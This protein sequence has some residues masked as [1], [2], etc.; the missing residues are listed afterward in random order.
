MRFPTEQKKVGFV[1]CGTQ[2]GGT[3]ALYAYLKKHPEI[4]VSD[5]K[6][7][8]FFDDDEKFSKGEP[9]YS[10]Y[11]ARFSP[12]KS[13]KLV[14]ESTPQYMYWESAP[15]RM[16][17]YN[18]DMKLIVLLRNPIDRAYSHWN[19]GRT[20]NHHDLSFWDA[21]T[22]EKE[23]ARE[24]LPLQHKEHSYI[25]RG[26][27]LEQLK[28]LWAYFP[29]EHVLV[30]KS[31]DLKEKPEKTLFL[32]CEFLRITPFKQITA[33]N[34]HVRPYKSRMSDKEKEYLRSVFEPGIRE[35]EA[36]LNWDCDNWL[37]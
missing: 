30:I 37:N 9:D 13:H 21:I 22:K 29:K 35:L 7:V 28:R 36:E 31:E 6:E 3:T 12:K 16:W 32:V 23:V 4:A 19:M 15:K 5:S 34:V 8:H 24:A 26:H 10:K 18:P 20:K 11:H 17:E 14:G 25:A 27:Y 33:K 2:K 1:I